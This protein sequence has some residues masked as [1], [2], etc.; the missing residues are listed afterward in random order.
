MDRLA[1]YMQ[2]VNPD[3]ITFSDE[4]ALQRYLSQQN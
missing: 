2:A 4:Q 1:A 3:T